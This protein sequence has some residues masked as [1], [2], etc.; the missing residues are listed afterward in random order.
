MF[1]I[2]HF[3]TGHLKKVVKFETSND[4]SNENT[5]GA[6]SSPSTIEKLRTHYIHKTLRKNSIRS[7]TDWN[8]A[9]KNNDEN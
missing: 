2:W 3:Y 5:E 7:N 4:F 8:F 1:R 9:V 6:Y